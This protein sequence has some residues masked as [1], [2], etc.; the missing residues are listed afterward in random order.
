MVSCCGSSL[1]WAAGLWR[2]NRDTNRCILLVSHL[3]FAVVGQY[4]GQEGGGAAGCVAGE[5]DAGGV[6]LGQLQANG[7]AQTPQRRLGHL[8]HTAVH[9][10]RLR[11]YQPEARHA[12]AS[13][14]WAIACTS[15]STLPEVAAT[16]V[17]NPSTSNDSASGASKLQRWT[18]C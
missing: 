1:V 2:T 7:F 12:A 15:C 5:I 18:M 10:L 11:R 14:A 6:Q 4:L 3:R 8:G 16:A 17:A 9:R 13:S